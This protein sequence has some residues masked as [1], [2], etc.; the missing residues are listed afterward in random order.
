MR[1]VVQRVLEASVDVDGRTVAAIG[2]GVVV[3][4]GVET[5]DTAGD[6]D[7]LAERIPALR[8][9]PDDQGRMNRALSDLAGEVLLISQFTLAAT[10]RRGRRP[11][12]E[13]AA[14]PEQAR[15]L[16]TRLEDRIREA[17]IV[18]RTGVFGALMRVHLVNDGPATF[19]LEGR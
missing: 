3:L 17:G 13:R 6:A 7:R 18:V 5:G 14:P 2:R 10:V 4:V 19:V 9:F 15:A 8:I 1:A 11:G 12:F 16:L